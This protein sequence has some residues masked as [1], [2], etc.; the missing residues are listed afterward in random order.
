MTKIIQVKVKFFSKDNG[1]RKELPSDL[2]STGKY[3]PHFIV[4]DPNQK[5]PILD[6]NNTNI[7]GCNG[8]CVI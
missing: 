7:A 8:F 1:G 2:L 4:G 3:R 5:S 6:Q